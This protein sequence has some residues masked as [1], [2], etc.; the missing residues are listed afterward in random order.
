M[1]SWGF[2]VFRRGRWY[3]RQSALVATRLGFRFGPL[4]HL[5]GVSRASLKIKRTLS[6]FGSSTIIHC[7][8][9][10]DGYYFLAYWFLALLAVVWRNRQFI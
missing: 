9:S 10:D 8:I 3:A 7:A 4:L 1:A 2:T 5:M 6:V